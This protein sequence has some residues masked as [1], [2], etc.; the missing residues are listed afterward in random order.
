MTMRY[1]NLYYITLHYITNVALCDCVY[2]N[3]CFLIPIEAPTV[4][5][6]LMS[7]REL[8]A[9][10]LDNDTKHRGIFFA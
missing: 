2:V 3:A 4:P 10:Q 6:M 8:A 1:I 5:K 7:S 9:F